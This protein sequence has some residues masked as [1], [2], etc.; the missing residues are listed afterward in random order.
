VCSPNQGTFVDFHG[1]NPQGL[2]ITTFRMCNSFCNA[3]YGACGDVDMGGVSV[4]QLF[5]SAQAWCQYSTYTQPIT[6]VLTDSNC[7]DSPD[8]V[9][10]CK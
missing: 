2:A 7:L 3:F 9:S 5:P 10:T 4:K 8:A 6:V 1:Y